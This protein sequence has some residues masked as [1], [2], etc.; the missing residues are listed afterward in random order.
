MDGYAFLASSERSIIDTVIV[1]EV[2][3]V[4]DTFKHAV[5]GIIRTVPRIEAHLFRVDIP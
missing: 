5:Q 1:A 2:A 3:V 4:F